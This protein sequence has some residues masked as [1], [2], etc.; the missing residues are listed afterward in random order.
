[1]SHNVFSKSQQSQD[2]SANTS[3]TTTT[4]D[5]R[6]VTDNGSIAIN[7]DNSTITMSDMGAIDGAN[8][9]AAAGAM[10]GSTASDML[11]TGAKM[12]TD[13]ANGNSNLITK[14]LAQG[15]AAIQAASA[16]GMAPLNANNPNRILVVVALCVVAV[17]A[18]Q[19]YKRSH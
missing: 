10:L 5:R 6:Q 1:M 9:I 8:H 16:L 11:A 4:Q 19:A 14:V 3:T 2:T 13:L 17:F 7:A 15:D 12:A 18:V